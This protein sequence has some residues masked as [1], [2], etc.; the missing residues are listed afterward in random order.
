MEAQGLHV[1]AQK[2]NGCATGRYSAVINESGELILGLADVQLAEQLQAAPIVSMLRQNVVDGLLVDANLS[3]DCLRELVYCAADGPT[4][5][6]ALTVSPGKALKLLPVARHIPLLFC[7]RRE[8]TAMA[9]ESGLVERASDS[10]TL[11]LSQLMEF[12]IN[13]GFNDCVLTDGGH[14]LIIRCQGINTSLPI[15]QTPIIQNVNG[16]GDALAGASFAAMIAGCTLPQAVKNYGLTQAARV[17]N[18]SSPPSSMI[19]QT[20]I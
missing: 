4:R 7:N 20:E 16:A 18:G 15:P 12:L 6:A 10:S 9:I 17:L 3:P 8:A 14:P 1:A 19:G 11:T 13:M 5:L 2:I